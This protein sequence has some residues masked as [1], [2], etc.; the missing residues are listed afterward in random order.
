MTYVIGDI[1]GCINTLNNLLNKI[2]YNKNYQLIFFGYYIYR[3][4][5]S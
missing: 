4:K 2:D 3:E 5:Y 1:H